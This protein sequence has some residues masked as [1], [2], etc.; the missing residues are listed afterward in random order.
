[1]HLINSTNLLTTTTNLPRWLATLQIL[2]YDSW[3]PPLKFFLQ[4]ILAITKQ[5]QY[6]Q[7]QSWEYISSFLTAMTLLTRRSTL[8]LTIWYYDLLMITVHSGHTVYLTTKLNSTLSC[9]KKL[10]LRVT[11][12]LR[13]SGLYFLVTRDKP[14]LRY[15]DFF[16][17]FTVVTSQTSVTT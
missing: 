6:M 10:S 9:E 15:L 8:T 3:H 16:F 14:R 12:S 11:I 7:I 1:M 5:L 17:C 4:H 13:M 2:F